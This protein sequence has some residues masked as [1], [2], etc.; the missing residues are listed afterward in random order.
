MLREFEREG[1]K[2]A[3]VLAKERAIDP[4]SCRRHGTF[5]INEDALACGRLRQLE[6]TPIGGDEFVILVVEVVPG[7]ADV[8]M[9]NDDALKLRVVEIR[10][11]R[12]LDGRRVITPVAIDRQMQSRR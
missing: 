1:C 10:G 4:D 8:S 7:Q 12:A 9:R 5:E 6:A 11:F 2:A 3:L